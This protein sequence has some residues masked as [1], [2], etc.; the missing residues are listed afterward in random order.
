MKLL[1][2]DVTDSFEFRV[3]WKEWFDILEIYWDHVDD[4]TTLF[5]TYRGNVIS[6]IDS[7]FDGTSLVVLCDDNKIRKVNIDKITVISPNTHEK[8]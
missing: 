8:T 4:Y 3:Q 7:F 2:R 6:V 1:A 5:E